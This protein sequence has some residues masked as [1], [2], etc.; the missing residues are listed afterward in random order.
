MQDL[1]DGP[2]RTYLFR[3]E[4]DT[5]K[6]VI[7]VAKQEDFS[8]KQAH[9]SSNSYRPPRRQESGGPEPMDFCYAESENSCV[10][11]YMKLQT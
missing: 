11:N 1:T 9:V 8:V 7:R 3:L 5:L 2:V 6:E 4:F 10:T